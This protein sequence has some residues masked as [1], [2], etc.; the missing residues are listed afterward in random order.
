MTP[1][2]RRELG[3]A[4]LIFMLSRRAT[5]LH[6]VPPDGRTVEMTDDGILRAV[7]VLERDGFLSDPM[8]TNAV[9]GAAAAWI[10]RR[11]G[12]LS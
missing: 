8:D 5:K 6:G 7:G 9:V 2:A 11:K 12:A 10:A 3:D 1:D 4:V